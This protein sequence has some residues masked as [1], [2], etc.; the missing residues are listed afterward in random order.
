[1][2]DIWEHLEERGFE[3]DGTMNYLYPVEGL[4]FMDNWRKKIL[5]VKDEDGNQ[6]VYVRLDNPTEEV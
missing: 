4:I 6:Q 5:V 2:S 3:G 1:M